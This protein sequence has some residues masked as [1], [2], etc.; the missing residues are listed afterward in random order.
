MGR[1][2]GCGKAQKMEKNRKKCIDVVKCSKY[3][4]L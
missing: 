2:R 4:R 3:A 1:V